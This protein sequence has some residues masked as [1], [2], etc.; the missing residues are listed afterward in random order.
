MTHLPMRSSGATKCRCVCLRASTHPRAFQLCCPLA[1]ARAGHPLQAREGH[2]E[3]QREEGNQP[4]PHQRQACGAQGVALRAEAAETCEERSEDED[5]AE[6]HVA[7]VLPGQQGALEGTAEAREDDGDGCRHRD[8]G[9]RSP[10][11]VVFGEKPGQ[12]RGDEACHGSQDSAHEQGSP[13]QQ[14]QRLPQGPLR[15]ATAGADGGQALREQGLSS[16]AQ[17]LRYEAQQR[18]K[19]PDRLVRGALHHAQAE[20]H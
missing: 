11:G 4:P 18:P 7:H 14:D 10:E 5:H 2:G 17:W 13:E 19:N 3:A 20:S 12:E 1:L 16:L 6:S 15:P 8:G 9:H